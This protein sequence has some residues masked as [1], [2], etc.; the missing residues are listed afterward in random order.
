MIRYGFPSTKK[1]SVEMLS[2]WFTFSTGYGIATRLT[3]AEWCDLRLPN[4]PYKMGT[5]GPYI[6]SLALM[7]SL[8]TLQSRIFPSLMYRMYYLFEGQ[9]MRPRISLD[10]SA[11]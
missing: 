5:S 8:V 9:P 1:T 4:S 7:L 3:L 6:A 2:I 11:P 10:S